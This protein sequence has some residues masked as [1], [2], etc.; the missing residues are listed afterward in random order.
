MDD[1]TPWEELRQG[2]LAR[3]PANVR[4]LPDG[5]SARPRRA[6][7]A[8]SDSAAKQLETITSVTALRTV[9]V[10]AYTEAEM[11]WLG[12]LAAA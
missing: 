6:R 5:S 2:R 1:C 10:V 9:V 11:R 7:I 8:F 3:S 12:K 4:L